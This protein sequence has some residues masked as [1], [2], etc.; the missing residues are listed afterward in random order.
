MEHG[1][2]E[3]DWQGRIEEDGI[4]KRI[5]QYDRRRMKKVSN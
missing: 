4:K 5:G 3:N 2:G 1:A